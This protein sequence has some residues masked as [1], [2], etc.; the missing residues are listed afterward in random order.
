MRPSRYAKAIVAAIAAASAA[1]VTATQDDLITTT[2][3]IT[4]AV[5]ALGALG[6]TYA[7]PNKPPQ[8]GDAR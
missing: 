3:W 2:E 7:V 8:D 4:I 5:A 6:V 1:A